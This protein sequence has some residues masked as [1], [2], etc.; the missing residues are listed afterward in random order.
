MAAVRIPEDTHFTLDILGRY[1][2]N[3][4]DEA[5]DSAVPGRKYPDARPFDYIVLG[6]GSFGAVLATRLFNLD[7]THRHRVL[8]LEAGP[9]A[10]PEHVQNLPPGFGPSGKGTPGTVW[11]QPWESDSPMG[12][13]QRFPGLAF[14]VGGRS[15]FWG[16]WSPYFID[17]EV[18]DPS[19]PATVRTDLM[20]P[21]L[22]AA[23][24]S[25]S[26]LDQAARV[27]GTDKTNDF[28]TGPLHEA[29]ADH[30]FKALSN[31]PGG[32]GN[33]DLTGNR[34]ELNARED[35]EAPLAV[36][37]ASER[38]GFFAS[39]KF[40]SVQL[41][42]RALR[43]AQGEAEAASPGDLERANVFKRLM[44]VNNC[45][46]TRLRRSGSRITHVVVQPVE[47]VARN[48][49]LVRQTLPEREIELPHGG[50]VFM[51]L[52]TIESTRLALNTV[53]EKPLIGRNFMAH[54]R[55]NL[56]F[57]VP[58]SSFAAL[59]P[60]QEPDPLKRQK[61]R[62]LQVSALFVKGIH[63]HKDG[64]K[65]HYHLQVTASGVGELGMN[66]EAE[67]F[68]KIPN[69]EELDQFKDLT[70]PWVVVTLR[71]IGEMVGDKTSA[72]PQ[73]RITLGTP[74][75]NGVPRARV[76]LETNW[77]DPNDPR[78]TD[79]SDPKATKDNELWDAMDA[80]SE[81][82]AASFGALGPVQYLSRPNQPENAH[83][84]GQPPPRNL[85]RDTL[86]STH[87]EAGS[88]W[89]G[90]QPATSITDPTGRI[91]E[92][93]NLYAVGPA[94]LPTI[95]SP[96]PMLS[97]VALA[98]RTADKVLV[99]PAA[100]QLEPQFAY[101][102]DGTGKTFHRWHKAGPGPFVLQDGLLIAQPGGDHSV[103]F[104]AAE[105]FDDFVVRL[106]FRL[107]GPVDSFGKAIGNSG[108]FLRFRYP[109]TQWADVNQQEPRAGGNPAWVAA[110]TG[111]EVQIDEQGRD[112]FF[113]KHRTGAIYDVP[114][115]QVVNGQAEPQHQKYTAGPVLQP[116]RWY[117]YDIEVVGD[118]YTVQL[119]EV[120]EGQAT[121]FQQVTTFKKP[122]GK[123]VGRGMPASAGESSGYLGVQAHSG[124]V[125]FRHIRIR[126]L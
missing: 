43:V 98:R 125:A 95:G 123:Y 61:L 21:V 104:Y 88:L 82:L 28:V 119:G 5:L 76:R 57:R 31:R 6:G 59:D 117:E 115:G 120:Q 93:D 107:S 100:P 15:V 118:Q 77:S 39:N 84:Q 86:A 103:L 73:N 68:K 47:Y 55:S 10:L 45:S 14:C 41:L 37:G 32:P 11:G 1:G 35:L 101:L 112:F 64:S 122:A 113:D 2:C 4:L 52:G 16:G 3:T 87:H 54:L 92:L 40:S 7:R 38:P 30:L 18:A 49:S 116:H 99:A 62:E 102:F 69:I 26:Y 114:T 81:E 89:M 78:V 22:P 126:K 105:A 72:D 60:D 20:T 71:G 85:R 96:N 27:L 9:F 44:L 80:A 121:A 91:W 29:L 42:L 97:G 83:W 34:G 23:N 50:R 56:T 79:S 106:Q 46:V 124:P 58:R 90:D 70:D 24:P 66:S 109:H 36:A 53:P 51:G 65:G 8:V 17:S 19:W 111:F 48:G 94:L 110:A 33:D 75:G 12:F 25:E 13:N 67:L 74:D 108:V 63:S